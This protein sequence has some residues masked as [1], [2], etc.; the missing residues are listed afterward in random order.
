MTNRWRR[1]R[2]A[3]ALSALVVAGCWGPPQ[4]GPDRQAF[5]TVDAMFTAVS[6][7]EVGQLERC[8]AKLKRMEESGKLPESASQELVEIAESAKSGQ[9]ESAQERLRAFMRGQRR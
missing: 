8:L 5:K 7:R 9:W 2:A 6:L 3:A 4:M 1:V